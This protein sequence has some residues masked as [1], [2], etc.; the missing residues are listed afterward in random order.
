MPRHATERSRSSRD[1][2]KFERRAIDFC[3]GGQVGWQEYSEFSNSAL[4]V[5]SA[6]HRQGPT[7]RNIPELGI[8]ESIPLTEYRPFRARTLVPISWSDTPKYGSKILKSSPLVMTLK[9]L[10][11]A[12]SLASAPAW[13]QNTPGFNQKIPEK[14][15][16]PDKVE[17]RIGTLNFVDGVPTVG[18]HAEGI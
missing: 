11:L 8:S 3:N 17:T 13:A 16:T 5:L 15:I 7:T 10:I 6:C 9:H 1:A 2:L 4:L 12:L 14:I 18:D